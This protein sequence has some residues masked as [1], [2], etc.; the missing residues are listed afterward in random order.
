MEPASQTPSPGMMLISLKGRLCS[1]RAAGLPGLPCVISLQ[2]LPP[3]PPG[4]A[5]RGWGI[6]TCCSVAP[7]ME[8]AV[9]RPIYVP[10][11]PPRAE[12]LQR[13]IRLL[14][15]HAGGRP[16]SPS[17]DSRS[18]SWLLCPACD[19]A[20]WGEGWEVGREGALGPA[21]SDAER[22]VP[23]GYSGCKQRHCVTSLPFPTGD[24]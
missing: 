5:W 7:S 9:N 13:G 14:D 15:G 6:I 11:P 23:S 10:P 4:R 8:T 17:S 1:S 2:P 3:G 19:R 12:L 16:G 24:A 20:R 22:A 18:R 21:Q